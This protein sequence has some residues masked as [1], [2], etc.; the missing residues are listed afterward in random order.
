MLNVEGQLVLYNL[1]THIKKDVLS[2]NRNS[3]AGDSTDR[4]IRLLQVF[5][6]T[7]PMKWE[8]MELDLKK[9][10]VGLP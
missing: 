4:D 3:L 7:S 6:N 5:P 9:Y 10:E 1:L 8:R 2:I